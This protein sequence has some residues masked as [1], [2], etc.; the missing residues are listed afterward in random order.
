[1]KLSL[2]GR[3]AMATLASLALGLGMTACGGGTIAYLWVLGDQYNQITSYKVDDFTGN[4]TQSPGSP[5]AAQ[6]SNPV[7]IVVKPGGRY[8]Y[9]INQGTGGNQTTASASSGISVYA[10]GGDGVLTFQQS[11]HSQGYIPQWAQFDA[12]GNYLYVLDKYSPDGTGVGAITAFAVDGSTG[13][14][15]LVTN[16]NVKINNVPITYF[17]VGVS[18]LMMKTVGSCLMTID[19]GD[20]TVF[21]YQVGSAGSLNVVTTQTIFTGASQLSSINGNGSLVLLTDLVANKI[22]PYSLTSTCG[23]NPVTGGTVT[24]LTG[25]SRPVFSLIDNSGKYV[26]V[27]NQSTTN[28]TTTTP[29]SSISAFTINSSTSQLVPIAGSPYPVGSN[30]VCMVE[31]PTNQYIYVSNRNDGTVTGKI[32]NSTTGELSDLKRGSTFQASG[33]GACLALSGSV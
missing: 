6:G 1:M 10:V 33:L 3:I 29:Y 8:V 5:F 16:P 25:T 2:M 23:L 21:A 32:I 22:L 24:N 14:L 4:L 17:N 9:V 19:T 27:L 13:R 30:P 26:Y 7:S 28:T 11:Y 20:N 18:P 12:A 31:D 15:T